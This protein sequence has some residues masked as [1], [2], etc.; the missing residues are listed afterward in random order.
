[1]LILLHCLMTPVVQIAW[2]KHLVWNGILTFLQVF[3]I[4]AL[5]HIALEIED[6]FGQD[7]NDLDCSEM[8]RQMNNHLVLLLRG[9]GLPLPSL[10]LGAFTDFED[11]CLPSRQTV[12]DIFMGVEGEWVESE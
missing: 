12:H 4:Q 7:A 6:P 9:K 10:V 1:M 5:D 8:Q 11:A 3:C 2:G